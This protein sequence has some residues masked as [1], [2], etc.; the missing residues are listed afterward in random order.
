MRCEDYNQYSALC[1]GCEYPNDIKCSKDITQIGKTKISTKKDD[2]KIKLIIDNMELKDIRVI[3]PEII[4]FLK[5]LGYGID[6]FNE[7]RNEKG[8]L[9][10][11]EY[12][13][14]KIYR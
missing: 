9:K 6:R 7:I 14:Y 8:K 2:N 12:E 13:L 5:D 11:I 3:S 4:D 1:A 10:G